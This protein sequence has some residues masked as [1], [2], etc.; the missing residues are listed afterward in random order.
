VIIIVGCDVIRG[1]Y[2]TCFGCGVPSN[3]ITIR[4]LGACWA[5]RATAL[6]KPPSSL[7]IVNVDRVVPF[8]ATNSKYEQHGGCRRRPR[9][10]SASVLLP[11]VAESAVEDP[12]A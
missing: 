3:A 12:R 1:C 10:H 9:R 4:G 11:G 6:A 7:S 8:R 2:V 5:I